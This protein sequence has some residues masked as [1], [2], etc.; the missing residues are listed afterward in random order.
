[1]NSVTWAANP[2]KRYLTEMTQFFRSTQK[3]ETKSFIRFNQ[4]II[5]HSGLRVILMCGR[6]VQELVLPTEC[7]ETRL[8]LES[9][10]VPYVS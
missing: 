5:Q 3:S 10:E 9:G 4:S 7:K 8:K 2:I 6:A 1:M